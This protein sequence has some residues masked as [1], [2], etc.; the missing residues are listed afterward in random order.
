MTKISDTT[1]IRIPIYDVYTAFIDNDIIR[2][3]DFYS[4]GSTELEER[5]GKLLEKKKAGV[6]EALQAELLGEDGDTILQYLPEEM[7]EY[8]VY[9]VK[10]AGILKEEVIDKED[11]VYLKWKDK[12]GISMK[13][14]L[15]YAI[16][17]GWIDGNAVES[18]ED[19]VTAEEMYRM[20][21]WSLTGKVTEDVGFMILTRN[22]CT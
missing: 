10:E 22:N 15:L 12:S 21:A 16:G 18:G 9:L 14:F 20:A 3:K 17:K 11:E 8:F 4:E 5:T 6:V 19:Y 2:I 1:D 7:V 13:E